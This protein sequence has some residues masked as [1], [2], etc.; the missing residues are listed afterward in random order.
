ESDRQINAQIAAIDLEEGVRSDVD[1][2][3]EVAG[4][5]ALGGL[6]VP[7]QPDLLTLADAGRDLDVELLA[8]RQP[9]ALLAALDRLLQRHRHRYSDVEIETNSAG[10]KFKGACAPCAR[11]ST[12]AGIGEHA[13]E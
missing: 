13:V 11:A 3:Q 9:D 1:G 12:A 8:A 6:A 10:F 7:A 5:M 4:R 2:D